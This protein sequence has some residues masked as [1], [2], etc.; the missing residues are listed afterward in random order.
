MKTEKIDLPISGMSCASCASA[1]ESE[2]KKTE[3]V[4][5]ASVNFGVEKASV[6][7]DPAIAKTEN[8]VKAIR[9]TGYDV[10]T[11]KAT[12][13]IRGMHCASCVETIETTLWE[14]E[15]VV[16]A[17]VNFGT[18]KATVEFIPG[19]V[20]L[21]EIRRAMRELGY[22]PL[23]PEEENLADEEK[24]AQERETKTLGNKLIFS[25]AVGLIMFLGSMNEWFPWMPN[26]LKN[27][28]TLFILTTP[29]QFWAGWQFYKGALA[30][31]KHKRTDMN[32][33]IALGT[34]AAYLYSVIATFFPNIFL[35]GGIEPATYYDTS[36]II[37]SLILLGRFLESK[38][39]G[40]TNEA[41]RKLISLG[42]KTASVMK[43]GDEVDIPV[44]EVQVGDILVVR[45]GEKIPVDGIVQ[46]GYSTVDESM[47]TGEPI[48]S[49]KK[50]GDKVIGPTINRTGS[51]KFRATSVGKDTVLSQIIKLVEEA[52]ASKAPIQRLADIIALYFVPVVI[53][54]AVLTF[55]IWYFFGPA[56]TFTYAFLNFV[57]VLIIACPCALGL[58]TPTA[59]MVG[60]GKGAE[61]GV[62]IKNAEALEMARKINVIVFD[63][64]G[65]LTKGKPEVTDIL[66]S[67]EF[68]KVDILRIVSS[69]ESGS[70]H[71]LSEAIVQ[72]AKKMGLN[73]KDSERFSAIPGEGIESTV[74][75]HSVFV[76]NIKL[77]NSKGIDMTHLENMAEKLADEGKIPVFVSLDKKGAGIIAV[78]DTLKPYSLEVVQAIKNLGIE[79][80]L[81]TGDNRRTAEAIGK[82]L[83]ID[84]VFAE[85]A[86]QDK[87]NEIKKLQEEGKTVAMVG[88]GINDAPAL[89]QADLGIAIG[90]GTDIA[91][92]SG[93]IVLIG[94][95]LRGV[96]TAIEL[97]RKTISTIKQNFFWAFFYNV[98]LIP[99][100]AGVLYPFFGILLN[101]I[102]AAAAMALSSV[103]VVSNSL[104]LKRFK[105]KLQPAKG[106]I[107][108]ELRPVEAR[109]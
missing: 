45:P 26:I 2:L 32:T 80:I 42:A 88:D 66:T 52:Q 17:N 16:S 38:A 68:P 76:G 50:A 72:H 22:E 92:E 59:I 99:L 7:F 12:I 87:A 48:P 108:S 18:E 101:P 14:M 57:A 96:I 75:G 28:I 94:D 65:T 98:L 71:P 90:A 47:I 69:A 102:L 49:E 109:G 36:A 107:S 64:T 103:S 8:L 104:R 55:I 40:K 91:I 11:Q 41:V 23:D 106:E 27:W 46:E 37:I 4:L 21:S 78:A 5:D 29:V 25:A 30:A 24:K 43:D 93:D 19:K 100:A 44:E 70:E 84:R 95:D 62:L 86:P 3:G 67:G 97:S 63:K 82:K 15:G 81:I 6:T 33:L 54:I 1:I 53:G 35:R 60:T 74:D 83:G 61:N 31:L 13:P 34:S 79:V 10:V 85:V 77:M 105:T 39:R 51:F 73:V 89:A 9:D 56:P 20:S 58:A